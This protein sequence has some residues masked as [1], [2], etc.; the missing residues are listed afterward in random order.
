MTEREWLACKDLAKMLDFL[1]G[2][3][4]ATASKAGRRKLRLFVCACCRQTWPLLGDA[5][6]AA[7]ETAEK[8]ADGRVGSD[9]LK[10]AETAARAAVQGNSGYLAWSAARGVREATQ[11]NIRSALTAT[12]W[13]WGALVR[14]PNTPGI[15]LQPQGK[16]NE[17]LQRNLLR[18]IFGNLFRPATADPAWC[19]RTATS[20]A[21][22]IYTDH[23]AD[24]MPILAD[25]LEEAGCSDSR[26]LT[27]CR[28]ERVHVRGCWVLDLIGMK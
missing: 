3:H 17:E 23:A 7:L 18:D 25:A 26:I 16:K 19:T 27:H 14:N 20:L 15:V 10:R 1:K 21:H 6:R 5:S 22:S 28:E 13:S 9:E 4:R 2:E 11:S 8:Y 24:R 12:Y